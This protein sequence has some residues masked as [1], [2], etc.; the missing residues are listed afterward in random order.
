MNRMFPVKRA[1]LLKFQL[2]LGIPP[3]F[4]GGIVLPLALGALER[5]QFH[6]LFLARHIPSPSYPW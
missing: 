3:V 1:I 6:H 4:T 2:F 5:Y